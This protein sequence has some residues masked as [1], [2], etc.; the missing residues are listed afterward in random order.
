MALGIRHCLNCGS[1]KTYTYGNNYEMWNKY[2]GGYLCKSCHNKIITVPKW[3]S[4]RITFKDKRL[5]VKEN[6]RTGI[7]SNCGSTKDTEI[8]HITY[9]NNNP[10][11]NTVELCSVCHGKETR[12]LS[13]TKYFNKDPKTGRFMK[14]R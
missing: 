8:H 11:M 3:S 13:P 6:P 2:K 9:D 1:D 4:R 7:C 5:Y 12:R 14:W 10:L